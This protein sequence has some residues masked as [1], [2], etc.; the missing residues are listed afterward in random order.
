[1]RADPVSVKV[2]ENSRYRAAPRLRWALSRRSEEGT[3]WMAQLGPWICDT[4]GGDV[5]L[6][7]GV[8]VWAR[9]SYGDGDFRIIHRERCDPGNRSHTYSWTVADYDG[10]DG[11]SHLMSILRPGPIKRAIGQSWT[12]PPVG[13]LDEFVD[14]V[15]RMQ[16]PGYEQ[17]R[18]M[19]RDPEVLAASVT[20]TRPLRTCKKPSMIFWRRVATVAEEGVAP[21]STALFSPGG[22]CRRTNASPASTSRSRLR[23]PSASGYGLGRQRSA[24]RSGRP[25]TM[26][27][28]TPSPTSRRTPP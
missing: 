17:V 27:S 6:D 7:E 2:W 25:M 8:V 20:P 14:L 16:I 19:S 1:M 11:L 9:L 5:A 4:C 13:D 15:R 18:R 26:P 3:R 10:P 12:K 24:K 28:R 23:S 22:R 21:P